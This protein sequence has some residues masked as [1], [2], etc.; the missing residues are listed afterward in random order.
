MEV[1]NNRATFAGGCFW[2]IVQPFENTPGV[3]EVIS[4]YAG[5]QGEN[6][7]YQDFAQKGYK[8]V[9]QITFDPTQVSYDKL[10]NIF[11]QQIDPTDAGGQFHDRGP[12]YQTAI[13]YH[14]F[15]QKKKA[16]QSKHELQQSGKFK[17]NIATE[18]IK[19]TNF[20][21]AE[22]YHQQFY[23][24]NPEH[25]ESYSEA[26]GRKK[27]LETTWADAPTPDTLKQLTPLQYDVIRCSGT[28]PAF[29]NEYWNN[30][31]PGIYVDR[32]SGE[33]L[34]SSIDKYDSGTG[35]PSFTKP[36]ESKN[37]TEHTDMKLNRERTEVRS[38]HAD[39]HLGHVF[40]DGPKP[41]GL[42]YCINSAAL[43]FI[44]AEDLEKEG[45]GQYKMLF[46]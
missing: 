11:W 18:I 4:G 15:E 36:L 28:E 8:E 32:I 38:K 9:V 24:N 20:Y 7:T 21:P 19:Y 23:K 31:N 10:L 39:S 14:N 5:G 16:E 27:F 13:F 6:P 29:M 37:V 26:S 41:G 22:Q 12:Q 42:R 1:N 43:R 33:P 46:E 25:Y 35:W 17:K 34:F 2:C 30:K 40:I 44:P 3:I 45:Y